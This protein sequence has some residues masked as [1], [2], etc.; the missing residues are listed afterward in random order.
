MK[1]TL[2]QSQLSREPK[3]L[4]E[5]LKRLKWL[6]EQRITELNRPRPTL[7]VAYDME[8]K[9]I[10]ETLKLVSNYG[11][12]NADFSALMKEAVR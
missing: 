5:L 12:D 6:R 4:K 9:G 11:V 2:I 7:A 8:A 10:S 3:T 1:K